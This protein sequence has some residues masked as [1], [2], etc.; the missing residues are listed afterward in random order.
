MSFFLGFLMLETSMAERE[1]P[2]KPILRALDSLET[3]ISEWEKLTVDPQDAALAQ[4][5][6]TLPGMASTQRL[7]SGDSAAA[8]KPPEAKDIEK[9]RELLVQLRDQI[10]QLS[11]L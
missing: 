8:P 5:Q 3:A 11:G 10:K 9:T 7:L 1:K 4:G 2:Q 6:P